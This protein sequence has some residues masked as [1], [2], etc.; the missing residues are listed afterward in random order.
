MPSPA[1]ALLWLEPPGGHWEA[2]DSWV[3]VDLRGSRK[4]TVR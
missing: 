1:R 2:A 3:S 4:G